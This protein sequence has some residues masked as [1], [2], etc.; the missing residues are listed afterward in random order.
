[1]SIITISIE[2]ELGWGMH[3][4]GRYGHLSDDGSEERAFLGALLSECERL[5]LPVTFD[6]VGHLFL[7][8]CAG[9]HEGPYPEGWFAA[10]PGTDVDS[11]PLFYAPDVVR[12][13]RERST[14]HELCTHT[15]S[16]VL[17][18]H[19]PRPTASHDLAR[20]QECH[21]EALGEP[22]RSLV[23]PRHSRPPLELLEANSLETV[24][25]ARPTDKPT[26][27]HRAKELVWGPH[28]DVGSPELVDGIVE[29]Y[30]TNY[31]SLTG[32]ALPWGQKPSYPAFRWLPMGL[33]QRLH[34]RY[35]EA[36]LRRTVER[37]R[38]LHLWCHLWDL[39]N[40]Y[41]WQPLR[42]FLGT[43]A[44]ARDRGDVDVLTMRALGDR[45]RE[46]QRRS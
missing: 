10:D 28:P 20:A 4:L 12:T 31:Q 42:G 7:E 18:G 9:V 14:D 45:V 16:H 39:S 11:D 2:I 23:P 33:R 13:V 34:R 22:A 15:F 8:S 24:R 38:D 30:C 35:L 32:S 26:P 40:P 21:E 29:I 46:R 37:D 6:V 25:I 19:A 27:I 17:C 5:D 44:S 41:Q 36:S 43:L 1:M 3:D